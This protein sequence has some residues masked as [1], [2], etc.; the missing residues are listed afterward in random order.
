MRNSQL[1]CLAAIGLLGVTSLTQAEQISF[2]DIMGQL[3]NSWLELNS[4]LLRE[5]MTTAAAAASAIADHPKPDAA[6]RLRVMTLLGDQA[7]EFRTWDGVVHDAAV[8]L[9]QAAKQNDT[10]AAQAAY[11]KVL[12]GCLGCHTKFQQQLRSDQ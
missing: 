11:H 2:K 5:D 8:E 12:D 3:E 6:E 7:A 4:A 1:R 10:E 9:A